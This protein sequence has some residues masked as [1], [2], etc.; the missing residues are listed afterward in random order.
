MFVKQR[1]TSHI[2]QNVKIYRDL[3]Y[4]HKCLINHMIYETG[5]AGCGV[6]FI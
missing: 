6:L 3:C 2:L 4:V 1:D 5:P